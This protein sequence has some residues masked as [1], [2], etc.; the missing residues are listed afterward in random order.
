VHLNNSSLPGRHLLAAAT[1]LVAALSG[2]SAGA[3]APAGQA[4]FTQYCASCHA[5]DRDTMGPPLGGVTRVLSRDELRQ[6]IRNSAAVLASGNVRANAL[7]RRYKL[8]MPPFETLPEEQV[9]AIIAYIESETERLKLTP[10]LVN[11]ETASGPITRLVPAVEKSGVVVELEDY[12]QIP[13]APNRRPDKGIATLRSSRHRDGSFY[14]SDQM[15]VIYRVMD[16]KVSVY[17]DIRDKLPDFVFEPGIGTG[18]GS[19]TFH[20]EFVRNGLIYTTHAELTPEKK[21]INDDWYDKVTIPFQGTPTLHWVVSEWK[22]DDPKA[23]HFTGTRREVLR[24]KTPTTAHG[25]QDLAFAPVDPKD[26]DYG[27]LF[28]GVGDGGS[29]N[30]KMPELAHSPRSL[31]G[32]VL[33]IDPLGTNAPAGSYGIPADN[34]FVNSADPLNRPEIWAF[35]FRNPHRMAWDLSY[36]KRMIVADIGESNV[37]EVNLIERGGDYGWNVIEGPTKVDVLRDAKVNFAA[38]PTDLAAYKMPFGVYDHIDGNAISGG[39]VYGGSLE[40][41]QHKYVFGD[42]VSGRLFFMN[43]DAKLSDSKVYELNVAR[44]GAATSLGL[45]SKKKRAHLR[46]G[47]DD[48]TG[49][50]YFMTKEDGQVRRVVRAYEKK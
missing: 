17:L 44:E 19:F 40:A 46:I 35:G 34:P 33:R 30:L 41:L 8:A 4:L 42:I 31:L 28:F 27:L 9:T 7:F 23:E 11:P 18:L 3:P 15:G 38:T 13:L 29:V 5:I 49:D 50:L 45:F 10:F 43:F 37:E 21:A 6:Q 20:P 14:V 39:F 47:Y 24:I 22:I 25:C 12:V 2:H 32:T 48:V 36:G 26:P 1:F 16:R